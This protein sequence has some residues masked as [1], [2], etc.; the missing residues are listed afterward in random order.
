MQGEPGGKVGVGEALAS[1]W[2]P[3]IGPEIMG[4]GTFGPQQDPRS[5]EALKGWWGDSP[6]FHS[7]VFV[8]PINPGR[9]S[10]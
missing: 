3:G 5:D 9:P 4:R 6:P 7:P 1:S 8:R 2:G 10:R